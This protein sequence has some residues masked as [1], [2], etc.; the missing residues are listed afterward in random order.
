MMPWTRKQVRF[1]FSKVSPLSGAEKD[2]MHEEL[3]EEPGLG[4]EKKG[5][6]HKSMQQGG[7]ADRTD[8]YRLHRG[9]EV[10]PVTT[11]RED[12][13]RGQSPPP[14]LQTIK[15]MQRMEPIM[16]PRL[17]ER[18]LEYK[19]PITTPLKQAVSGYHAPKFTSSQS[20]L[21]GRPP[22]MKHGGTV[23][24]TGVYRLHQGETV[25]PSHMVRAFKKA[26]GHHR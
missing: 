2:K 18:P 4:H 11:S 12:L 14:P 25:I 8:D 7:T 1:L 17:E 26:R 3:H 15:A 20:G 16:S 23:P 22:G 9:E 19:Q 21:M 10:L 13:F 6:F 5:H 24:H